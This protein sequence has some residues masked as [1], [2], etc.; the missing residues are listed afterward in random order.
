MSNIEQYF[1]NDI[2]FSDSKSVSIS[3]HES[4]STYTYEQ[5]NT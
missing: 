2:A 1:S 4:W 3:Y 5:T